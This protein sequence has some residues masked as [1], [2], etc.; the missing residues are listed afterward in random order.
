MNKV[1]EKELLALL[2][3]NIKETTELSKH[4]KKVLGTLLHWLRN[5]QAEE[6]KRIFIDNASLCTIA[7]MSKTTLMSAI[8]EL[9]DHNLIS[10]NAGHKR[11]AGEKNQASEYFIHWNNL[12]K[13]VEKYDFYQAFSEFF[14]EKST[15]DRES[16]VDQISSDQ[17]SIDKISIEKN[18]IDQKR[19]DKL[20]IDKISE[21]QKSEDKIRKDNIENIIEENINKNGQENKSLNK[22]ED[23]IFEINKNT[24]ED[25]LE[26]L[27]INK[28]LQEKDDWNE[29]LQLANVIKDEVENLSINNDLKKETF[30]RLRILFN[31]KRYKLNQAKEKPVQEKVEDNTTTESE[32]GFNLFMNF[33][34]KVQWE[35]SIEKLQQVK[36]E[37]T[38]EAS[39]QRIQSNDKYL[40]DL[41]KMIDER[42]TMLQQEEDAPQE[43]NVPQA[44]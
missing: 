23:M 26:Y 41:Y 16:T 35:T 10:R 28:R 32:E 37:A 20:S 31:A 40:I 9:R 11:T 27:T 24:V 33:R 18:S 42:I 30:N 8:N 19:E 25:I 43:E 2:P 12:K 34:P 4:A 13:P 7:S 5:S 44:V 14:D 17:Y 39:R 21:D 1:K 38:N 29:C 6:T 3:A 15:V 22:N 36:E